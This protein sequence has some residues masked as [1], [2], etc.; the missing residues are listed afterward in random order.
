MR[1]KGNF[2]RYTADELA[3]LKSETDWAKVDATTREEIERYAEADD[4]PLAAGWEDTVVLGIPS[5]KRGVYLRL[6]AD[7]LDWFK[8][9]GPGYQTRIN[10]VLRAFVQARRNAEGARSKRK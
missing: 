1:R 6:D 8:A 5:P 7:V 10:A 9:H 2:V 4:G 3:Y